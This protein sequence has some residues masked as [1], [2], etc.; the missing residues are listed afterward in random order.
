MNNSKQENRMPRGTSTTANQLID[1]AMQAVHGADEAAARLRTQELRAAYPQATDDRLVELLIQKKCVQTGMIGAVTSGAAIVPGLG[2]LATLTIGTLTDVG[3]SLKMQAELVLEI[4]EVYGYEFDAAEKRNALMLV[5]GASVGVEELLTLGGKRLA[6]KA[7]QR[8]TQRSVLKAIPF[9]GIGAAAAANIFSTY[10]IGKRADA[11]FRLGPEAMGDWGESIRAISGV[12]ER[13]LIGW[14]AD[15]RVQQWKTVRSHAKQ[16]A[17][18][19]GSLLSKVEGSVR[20]LIKRGAPHT[21]HTGHTG[22]RN[23]RSQTLADT[24][25]DDS[26]S[27]TPGEE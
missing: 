2:T 23:D 9:V 17:E 8:V 20:T 7:S 25:Y 19:T 11:Y 26:E 16:N 12:D 1:S 4:A 15:L 5:T 3:M 27:A 24:T 22:A 21:S 18:R 13:K 6:Q 10:L 14:L